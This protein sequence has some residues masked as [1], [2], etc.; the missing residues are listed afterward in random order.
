MKQ[1]GEKQEVKT[2][3]FAKINRIYQLTKKTKF[4]SII[5]EQGISLQTLQTSKEK[6]YSVYDKLLRYIWQLI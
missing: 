1:K 2:F 3:Y 4:T 6:K 5:N